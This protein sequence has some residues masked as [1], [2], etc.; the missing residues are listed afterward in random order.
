[1]K[2]LLTGATGFVGANVVR[3][4]LARGDEVRCV[5]RKPNVC[6]EGLAVELV[7]DKVDDVDAMARAAEGCEAILHVA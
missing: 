6:V 2:Y 1:M 3:H 7:G 5:V 4:L